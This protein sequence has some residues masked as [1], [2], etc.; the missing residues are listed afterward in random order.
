VCVCVCVCVC[1]CVRVCVWER[2]WACEHIHSYLYTY[3]Y[4]KRKRK[5]S[6]PPLTRQ[7]FSKARSL[8]NWA[9]KIT[10]GLTF[11]KFH[12]AVVGAEGLL[13]RASWRRV[14]LMSFESSSGSWRVEILKMSGRYS[15]EYIQWQ[16]SCVLRILRI[17]TMCDVIRID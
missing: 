7:K 11:E 8:L 12:R 5:R 9:C 15:I 10:R 3:V 16:E 13:P 17:V 4:T 6:T 1:A 14:M 2:E